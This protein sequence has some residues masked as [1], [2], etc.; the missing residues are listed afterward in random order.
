MKKKILPKMTAFIIMLSVLT[1]SLSVYA[2]D[3]FNTIYSGTLKASNKV[4]MTI[5]SDDV[6]MTKVIYPN[7]NGNSFLTISNASSFKFNSLEFV[8]SYSGNGKFTDYDG[9]FLSTAIGPI[10]IETR[11]ITPKYVFG[12]LTGVTIVYNDMTYSST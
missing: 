10:I 12:F 6:S 2:A 5:S 3:T 4:Y 11:D 8:A 9:K 7:G 1:L